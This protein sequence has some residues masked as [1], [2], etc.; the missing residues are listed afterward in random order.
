MTL[1]HPTFNIRSEYVC[2]CF[3]SGSDD[4]AIHTGQSWTKDDLRSARF[5]HR[6]KEVNKKFAIDLIKDVPPIE[7]RKEER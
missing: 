6:P 7:V 1:M 3:Q 5:M 4:F 2:C